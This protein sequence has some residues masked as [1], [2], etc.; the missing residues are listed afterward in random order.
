MQLRADIQLQTAIR[1]LSEVVAPAVDASNAL[2]VEQLQIVIGMLHLMAARLPLQARFDCDELSR[3]LEFSTALIAALDGGGYTDVIT[4]LRCATG[5]GAGLLALAQ[6][7]PADILRVIRELRTHTGTLITTAYRD[8]SDAERARITTLTLAH[9]DAQ[10]LRERSWVVPMG[11]ER[12]PEDL[13]AIED[14]LK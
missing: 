4:T 3:L 11:W 6:A 14:L 9:A 8:G 7:D 12:Q 13:P 2:A 10:L 1:A 5:E